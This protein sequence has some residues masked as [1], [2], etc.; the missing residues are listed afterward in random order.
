M[1]FNYFDKIS[2][3]NSFILRFFISLIIFFNSVLP[4]FANQK[5][6]NEEIRVVIYH[7]NDMH[8][9][10]ESKRSDGVMTQIGLDIVK[11]AKNSTKNAILIDA[12]DAIQGSIIGKLEKGKRIIDLMNTAD[13]DLMILGNHEFDFGK[14]RLKEFSKEA[15]FPILAAN[16]LENGKQIFEENFIKEIAGRKI[17]FFGLTTEETI[18]TTIPENIENITFR[19]EIVTA[20]EQVS[21]LRNK[22]VDAIIAV[23]HLGIGVSSKH[24]SREIAQKV[25]GIDAIIDGHSHNEILE[26]INGVPISQT[27]IGSS[28]LGKME[29]IFN[30]NENVKVENSLISASD[31]GEMFTP[32]EKVINKYEK[33]Y[34]EISSFSEKVIGRTSNAIFGG[35]YH[36][37]NISRLF[38]T[39]AGN[40]ICDAM[41]QNGKKL[42]S[43][44]EFKDLPMVAFENGGSVKRTIE[45]GFVK[46][47]DVISVLPLDNKITAQ[48][49]T[50]KDLYQI[51]ERGVGKV[52]ITDGKI[53]GEFGGFPQISGM[54]FKFYA[55]KL[56]YNYSTN[57]GGSRVKSVTIEKNGG[58][59]LYKLKRDDDKTKLVF[60]CNDYTIYEFP[61][62]AK[63]KIIKKGEFLS[64]I[65]ADHILN[66]TLNGGGIFSPPFKDDRISMLSESDLEFLTRDFSATI[67]TRDASGP[68]SFAD[69]TLCCDDWE[70][71]ERKFI[72]DENGKLEVSLKSGIHEIIAKYNGIQTEILIANTAIPMDNNL[73]FL[74]EIGSNFESVENL[75]GQI[76]YNISLEEEKM[77]KFARS[78]YDSLTE[79]EK[80]SIL[81][82]IKLKNSEKKLSKLKG[83]YF[84][85][86]FKKDNHSII[87]SLVLL[88][89]SIIVFFVMRVLEKRK[90]ITLL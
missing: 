15:K 65:L 35:N 79:K 11:G 54:K 9:K 21:K 30:E 7:T 8:G 57:S 52:S 88:T 27:G 32:D 72:T 82:Y 4:L 67:S 18:R 56:G 89:I 61:P 51:L 23:T 75:I 28:N 5:K 86:I 20:V 60:L 80:T 2:S 17:G 90:R 64:D 13:Y 83:G 47:S 78:A 40:F 22:K 45:K 49:I 12:G 16:V 85:S 6:H 1:I 58:S 62:L 44:T 29:L 63:Q 70:W 42:M 33:I 31:A 19:D 41:M 50:P 3:C 36:N 84:E 10:I 66:L 71:K 68:L 37:R 46:M 81:N 39:S 53:A 25:P 87:I 34:D 43:D 14:E 38:E 77:I 55:D 48:L 24:T 74:N 76:P 26:K 59:G 69:I 73:L